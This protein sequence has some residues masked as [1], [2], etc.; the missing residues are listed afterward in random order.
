[1]NAQYV[2][3]CYAGLGSMRRS[4]SRKLFG[5]WKGSYGLEDRG[6]G[7]KS[8]VAVWSAA[9]LWWFQQLCRCVMLQLA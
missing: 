8:A 1:M 6:S 9:A 2:F 7:S 5:H 4:R 3:V